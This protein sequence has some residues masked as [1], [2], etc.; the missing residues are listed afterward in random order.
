METNY[1]NMLSAD[2]FRLVGDTAC[3]T[4]M[5]AYVVGGYVRDMLLGQIG[6]A[7]V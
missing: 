2:I 1:G 5:S 3:Q 6:R 7:H 4:G